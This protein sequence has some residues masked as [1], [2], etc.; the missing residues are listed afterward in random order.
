MNKLHELLNWELKA[1]SHEFP[2]PDGGTCINEAAIV[3]AGFDYKKV[4]NVNDLPPCFSPVFGSYLIELND[5]LIND[6]RQLLI[7][8]VLKLSGS[9]DSPEIEKQ[10]FNFIIHSTTE[11]IIATHPDLNDVCFKNEQ[12]SDKIG[13]L[14]DLKKLL[15]WVKFSKSQFYEDFNSSFYNINMVL[16]DLIAL[17][18]SKK[19]NFDLIGE[20]ESPENINKIDPI[21]IIENHL[22][23]VEKRKLHKVF[24]LFVNILENT[25]ELVIQK[26][27]TPFDAAK[28]KQVTNDFYAPCIKIIDEA[29]NI[30]NKSTELDI[31]KVKTRFDKIKEMA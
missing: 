4:T 6:T 3:A 8:F 22:A 18:E 25:C 17:I 20:K 10:R 19:I 11:H 2:G 26:N 31:A 24:S 21:F 23:S 28:L 9:A 29:F 30:G 13:T 1:G 15:L 14:D 27:V 12:L 7:P 5:R 16:D